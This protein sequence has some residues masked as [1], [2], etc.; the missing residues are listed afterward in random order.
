M[1][2]VDSDGNITKLGQNPDPEVDLGLLMVWF[3]NM[4][5]SGKFI[6]VPQFKF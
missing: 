1:H 4:T 3:L 6:G 5:I 2:L